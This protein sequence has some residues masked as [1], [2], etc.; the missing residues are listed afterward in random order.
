VVCVGCVGAGGSGKIM[1]WNGSFPGPLSQTHTTNTP[2]V[3]SK[4]HHL[5]SE[6]LQGECCYK[7]QGYLYIATNKYVMSP[8]HGRVMIVDL[9]SKSTQA[10]WLCWNQTAG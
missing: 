7:I 10:D 3:F 1:N 6:T 4:E 2:N 5:A 8:V 9:T